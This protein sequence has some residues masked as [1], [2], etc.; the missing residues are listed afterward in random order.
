M[1]GSNL[2]II[3]NSSVNLIQIMEVLYIF[4]LLLK[5]IKLAIGADNRGLDKGYVKIY[6]YYSDNKI[7]KKRKWKRIGK[8]VGDLT[9][10]KG[11][12]NDMDK[13]LEKCKKINNPKNR[14]KCKNK[15][16]QK[17]RPKM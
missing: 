7:F 4:L 8:L 14:K 17:S 2:V 11:C 15:P 10:G 3:R 6:Q 9:D 1:I 13:G 12:Y 16:S 5:M